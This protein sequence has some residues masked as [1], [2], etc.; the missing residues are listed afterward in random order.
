[1][2]RRRMAG[3]GQISEH[4]LC[5]CAQWRLTP[6]AGDRYDELA[7]A[8]PEQLFVHTSP[9]TP[10]NRCTPSPGLTPVPR[11]DTVCCTILPFKFSNP[12]IPHSDCDSAV[13]WIAGLQ[14]QRM[15]R[16]PCTHTWCHIMMIKR[17]RH[18]HFPPVGPSWCGS[19][20]LPV[21]NSLVS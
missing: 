20:D 14:W 18:K 15:A 2:G 19:G 10:C 9:A 5:A 16:N 4:W 13:G 7:G 6:I 1:M 11:G 12:C 8:Q 17:L 21:Q 3:L